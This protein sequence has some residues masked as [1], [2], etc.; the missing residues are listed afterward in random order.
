[1]RIYLKNE[2]LGD[3]KEIMLDVNNVRVAYAVLSIGVAYK[4]FAVPRSKLKLDITNTR[5]LQN[6]ERKQLRQNA[7]SPKMLA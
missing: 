1:M 2:A 7:P 5:F 4:L 3:I 6:M